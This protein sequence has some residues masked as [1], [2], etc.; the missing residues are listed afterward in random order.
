MHCKCKKN[1]ARW[2]AGRGDWGFLQ[3]KTFL[4]VGIIWLSLKYEK[5]IWYQETGDVQHRI[6][7]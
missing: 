1:Q 5:E 4:N 6:L 3:S 2:K 7:F